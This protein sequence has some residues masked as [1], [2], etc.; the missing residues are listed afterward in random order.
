[1]KNSNS[2][3]HICCVKKC[4]ENYNR[5]QQISDPFYRFNKGMKKSEIKQ[6]KHDADNDGVIINDVQENRLIPT[7]VPENKG[8]N[9]VSPIHYKKK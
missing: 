4:N 9:P 3:K 6:Q 8:P 7:C 5:F 2:S 1:M